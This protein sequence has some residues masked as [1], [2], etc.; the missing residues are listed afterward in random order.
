MRIKKLKKKFFS[1]MKNKK[2]FLVGLGI[3]AIF[4]FLDQITKFLVFQKLNKLSELTMG[5]HTHIRVTRFF[6]LVTVWNRGI[7]FGMLKNLFF[8]PV[9]LSIIMIAIIGFV[10]YLLWKPKDIYSML[11]LSLILGGAVGNLIDR[12][13]FGKVFDFLDFYIGKYHWPAFNV[14]DSIICIGVAMVLIEELAG[15]YKSKIKN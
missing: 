14:A 12:L 8:G 1:F 5:V 3:S 6:N 10:L 13:R 11:Y 7:S 15:N 4:I 9:I 2:L